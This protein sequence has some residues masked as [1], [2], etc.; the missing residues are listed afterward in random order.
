[1]S[2]RL[3]VDG[4]PRPEALA[5]TFYVYEVDRSD[6]AVRY[7]GEPLT[8]RDQVVDRVAPLFR[9]QGYRV[10]LRY[11]T[12]E[13]VLV[14][15][16]R[17]M[18]IDGIPWLNVV[19]FVATLATTLLAGAR[20][21]DLPIAEN[22][23]SILEA[24]PFAVAVLGVLGVH[25]FGHYALS[26]HHEVQA[27][28]PYFIPLPNV[29]GTLGAVIRMKDHLPSRKALFDI[30]VAGPLAGLV[31]TVVVTAVGVTLP[32]IEVSS[33]ALIRQVELGYPPLIQ[34]IAAALGEPLGYEDPSLMVN[35][36]VLGGWVGA[37]V[38]F[39]NLLPVGQLDGAHAVRALIGDR[40][41]QVQ[42]AVPVALFG[43]AGWQLLFGDVR[44]VGLW[45]LWGVLALVLSRVGGARPIDESGVGPTRKAI[46][47]LTLLL[48][49]L[50]FT[51]APIVFTG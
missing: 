30:G 11:E 13:H 27:T 24:W 9:E 19:L 6:G 18:G 48:G 35:P 33:D 22:P 16:Q 45:A 39:L 15:E 47:L 34:V 38:T 10:S 41:D 20:W 25:E 3:S 2:D 32:P 31:A 29:L 42:L 8:P 46:A 1:M 21:Y 12:G 49:V 44:A 43:V 40:L 26:R 51:P 36:V 5:N 50:C 28:L 4:Y 37:F 23:L 14:A 7:Y 17:T